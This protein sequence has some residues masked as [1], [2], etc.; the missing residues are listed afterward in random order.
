MQIGDVLYYRIDNPEGGFF[1][2]SRKLTERSRSPMSF[3]IVG[4]ARGR[5]RMQVVATVSTEAKRNEIMSRLMGDRRYTALRCVGVLQITKE[6]FLALKKDSG[7]TTN[8]KYANEKAREKTRK[9]RNIFK[10]R[11]G[12]RLKGGP[13]RR[14][15]HVLA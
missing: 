15:S 5:D 11:T 7:Y 14:A 8:P 9:F 3:G 10:E 12:T 6:R 13:K 1:L 4:R 2:M